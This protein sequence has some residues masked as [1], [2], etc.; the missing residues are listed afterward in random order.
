MKYHSGLDRTMLG[1]LVL[2]D[3]IVTGQDLLVYKT[4]T[5]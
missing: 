3:E 1:D 2:E 5:N 4:V